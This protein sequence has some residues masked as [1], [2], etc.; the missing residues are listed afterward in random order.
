MVLAEKM[1]ATCQLPPQSSHSHR[2]GLP[3]EAAGIS[4]PFHSTFY[5]GELNPTL[6]FRNSLTHFSPA[7]RQVFLALG[8]S[9]L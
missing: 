7:P 2:P 3:P 8:S 5:T 4:N 6:M 9:S 1:D